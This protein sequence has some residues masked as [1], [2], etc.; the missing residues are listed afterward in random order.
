[1]LAW[2]LGVNVSKVGFKY[3]QAIQHGNPLVLFTPTR[4]GGWRVQGVH[5]VRPSCRRLPR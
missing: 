1:M 4:H 2:T 5:Q 3:G